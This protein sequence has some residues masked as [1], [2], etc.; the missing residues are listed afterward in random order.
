MFV[1]PLKTPSRVLQAVC[2]YGER[3]LFGSTAQTEFT[4]ERNNK[5]QR[6]CHRGMFD[7]SAFGAES[8]RHFL[9]GLTPNPVLLL[10]KNIHAP[11]M[12]KDRRALLILG[13]NAGDALYPHS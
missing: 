12:L 8:A 4:A 11:R 2:A 7:L 1:V 3:W 9:S 13:A 10:P 5:R 6:K